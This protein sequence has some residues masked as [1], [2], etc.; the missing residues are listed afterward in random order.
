MIDAPCNPNIATYRAIIATNQTYGQYW[1]GTG[2][3]QPKVLLDNPWTPNKLGKLSSDCSGFAVSWCWK[4]TRH[5][6]GFNVG[7]WA[8]V[9]DDVNVNSIMED[10]VHNREL[11]DS[12]VTI[13]RPGDLL[14]YP[15]FYLKG[16]KK[17]FI[18]HVAIITGVSKDYKP[19]NYN[20]LTVVQCHGPDGF[21]PGVVLTDGSIFRH[22][23]ANWP[24]EE[25]R[26][27]IIRMKERV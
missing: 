24:K 15:T 12:V 4:I 22:H 19:G 27:K 13:P 17:P 18:G 6:K 11:A 21:T 3:Y 1:L 20:Q 9:S 5:R 26:C 25:H 8:S 23:D 2:D 16:I 14:C 7:K 10:A